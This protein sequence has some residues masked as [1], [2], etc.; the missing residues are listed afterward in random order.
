MRVRATDQYEK[1]NK[2][3]KILKRILKEG[4]EFEV[5]EERFKVLNGLNAFGVS[6]AEKAKEIEKM[7]KEI[8]KK[9]DI[10]DDKKKSPRKK[11]K[12]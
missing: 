9:E 12:E 3:D 6:F 2:K 11:K 7:S 10:T 5:S 8:S 1:L 4:E